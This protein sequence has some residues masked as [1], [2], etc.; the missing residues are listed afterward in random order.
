MG[1]VSWW[2][3]SRERAAA[4]RRS[5][6]IN[7]DQDLI[8]QQ[9]PELAGMSDVEGMAHVLKQI[10]EWNKT[11]SQE[12][13]ATFAG[14]LLASNDAWTADGLTM[15]YWGNLWVLRNYQR[16]LGR[17]VPHVAPPASAT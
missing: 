12:E 4:A 6:A 10:E 17:D 15:P 8:A 5:L 16:E 13:A 3:A 9:V 1:L 7:D 2:R 14:R 11:C